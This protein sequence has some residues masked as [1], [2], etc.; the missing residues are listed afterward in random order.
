MYIK[1]KKKKYIYKMYINFKNNKK[2]LNGQW[3]LLYN[4]YHKNFI[5]FTKITQDCSE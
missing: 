2:N 1:I 4:K 3:V 5:Q